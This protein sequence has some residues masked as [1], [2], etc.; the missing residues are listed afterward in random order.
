MNASEFKKLVTNHFSPN[1]RKLGWKG[2]GFNFR[3]IEENHIINLF[4]IQG[5]WMGGSVCC[6]TAID[7][8]F[9]SNLSG[10]KDINKLTY[11]SCLIRERLTP[12]GI[13]DYHWEFSQNEEENILSIKE[14]LQSFE[15]HGT[16]FFKNFKNFP[17]PFDK[18][19][20][21]DLKNDSNYKV[22]GK[23]F[24]YN[25]IEF[26][27]L[28]KDINILLGNKSIAQ[29][30]SDFGIQELNKFA[31]MRLVGRKTKSYREAEN[32]IEIRKIAL[33]I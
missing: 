24:I 20:P 25:Q 21:I 2:S 18:I 17:H 27:R 33:S 16:N 7:F 14:I 29:E 30:F 3:K 4:G 6:E 32:L 1:I 26:A 9:F 15:T 10:K 12:S 22:L 8:D 23:Y 11:A 13:G 19:K 31:K 5:N 28:L